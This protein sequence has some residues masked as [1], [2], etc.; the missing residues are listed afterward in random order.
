MNDSSLFISKKSLTAMALTAV[1]MGGLSGC[2]N[3]QSSV[4]KEQSQGKSE[5]HKA[6]EQEVI[7]IAP[8]QNSQQP[9][10]SQPVRTIQPLEMAMA[11]SADVAVTEARRQRAT[12][13]QGVMH[14]QFQ[15]K[16]FLHPT[17]YEASSENYDEYPENGIWTVSDKPV[18]TFS[19]DVDTASYSNARRMLQQGI[20]PP[21]DAIRVEEFLNYFDYQY[22]Q[23]NDE[24]PF[25][26]DATVSTSPYNADR[27]LMRIALSGKEIEEQNRAP[28]NLVFLLDVSGSMSSDDKLPLLKRGLKLMLAKLNEKD[29]VSIVVYAG[30]SGIVLE[31]T[32]GDDRIAI[33]QALDKL[34]AGGSTNGASGIELAYQQAQKSFKEGGINRV[35][36]ATDGDFNVGQTDQSELLNMIE[37]RRESGVFLSVL[38]FGS[39][40]Y[41]DALTEQLADKG[42]GNAAY[43]DNINEARK[44][45]VE[46]ITGTLQVIAKDVK[47]QVEFNPA[48][49]HEYRLIGYENRALNKED[50]NNDKV[51]AGDIGAGHKVTALYE[52]T[53]KSADSYTIDESRYQTPPVRQNKLSELAQVKLRYKLPNA[54][55]SI[56]VD[57]L[58]RSE[59]IVSFEQTDSEYRFAT[60]V[61]GFAQLLR[62]SKFVSTRDAAELLEVAKNNKGNDVSGYRGEMIQMMQT[63]Q[64]MQESE[65]HVDG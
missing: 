59:D 22:P 30:A 57:K 64:L 32:P 18:S 13:A 58:V 1:L 8:A 46:Q 37:K 17:H 50:F 16:P 5:D 21:K 4:S 56:R 51:D 44:V 39:G 55:S 28:A 35:I 6:A 47:I 53:L 3:S 15:S 11:K 23:P 10:T 7:A 9:Q 36:L 52:I 20:A 62:G 34:Q 25:F 29:S 31:P 38:G 43:I 60:A 49:V 54:D 27:H 65:N 41:N 63:W 40:N 26:V 48:M 45:L 12:R 61:A 19:V 42:N 14:M 2:S 24:H 33:S